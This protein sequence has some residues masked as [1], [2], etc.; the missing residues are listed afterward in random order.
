MQV[1]PGTWVIYIK[2]PADGLLPYASACT[3][4]QQ[5]ECQGEIQRETG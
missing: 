4:A 3:E 1:T 5:T 2:F